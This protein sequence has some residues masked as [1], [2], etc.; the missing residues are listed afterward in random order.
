MTDARTIA[1]DPSW[2]PH[3]IDTATRQVEFFKIAR[4][5]LADTG[6]LADR[7]PPP[8][9][10]AFVGWDEVAAMKP[11]SGN[12]HFIFHT[13][14]CRSTLLVRAVDRPGT[15]A[16][17]N[18]PFIIASM[19]NA[20]DAAKHL[21]APLLALLARPWSKGESVIVKP[22]N[23][24]NMIIPTVMQQYPQA[25]AVLMTND[26]PVFLR[27]VARKGLMGRSWARKLFIE[28]QSYAA[29]D[30]GL[31]PLDSFALTDMQAAA[32]AWF[33]N[34]R[35]FSAHLDNRVKG[36]A[37]DRFRLL[38]GDRFDAER[39]HTIDAMF[40]FFDISVDDGVA[41]K[42]A[43]GPVFDSHSKLGGAFAGDRA[44]E[45][46]ALA[47][48]IDQVGQWAGIIARQAGVDLPL[49]HSLF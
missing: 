44:T 11:G 49:K 41:D 13:A 30:F 48:E 36:V 40:A 27:S 38:D 26:L 21:V 47:E 17:L 39:A 23:H 2:L 42:L 35:Y 45:D 1:A 31:E 9:E 32:L 8:Q 19:V 24:A 6:F 15:V 20:G 14:F 10:R 18:E 5:T 4:D 29:M 43:N 37:A 16:V 3:R 25:R 34:Q 33:L 12:L 28:L 22:T 46:P 7:D